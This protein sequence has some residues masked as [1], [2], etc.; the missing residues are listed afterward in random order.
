MDFEVLKLVWLSSFWQERKNDLGTRQNLTISTS[1]I[2]FYLLSGTKKIN[3]NQF[4][5]QV[6]VTKQKIAAA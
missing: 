5:I 4:T 3:I 2:L 6:N 1:L